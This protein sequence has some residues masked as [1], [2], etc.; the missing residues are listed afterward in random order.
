MRQK[1][2]RFTGTIE[3]RTEPLA[4]VIAPDDGLAEDRESSNGR[5]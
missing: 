4:L 1:A 5:T 2:I 3:S